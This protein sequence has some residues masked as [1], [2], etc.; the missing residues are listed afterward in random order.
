MQVINYRTLPAFDE[1]IETYG[2]FQATPRS[3]PGQIRF[4][5]LQASCRGIAS[6]TGLSSTILELLLSGSAMM[7]ARVCLK[8]Q[9]HVD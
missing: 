9:V 5:D 2:K 1:H 4:V 7:W 3:S 8:R 6:S